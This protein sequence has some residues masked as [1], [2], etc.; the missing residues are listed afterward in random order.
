MVSLPVGRLH[1][2]ESDDLR[3]GHRPLPR[4]R[5]TGE[6]QRQRMSMEGMLFQ[7]QVSNEALWVQAPCEGNAKACWSPKNGAL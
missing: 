3:R 7:K 5:Q 4:A 1:R 6:R 2:L